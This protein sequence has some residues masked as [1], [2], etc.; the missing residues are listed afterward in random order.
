MTLARV[1]LELGRIEGFPD[2]SS[3]HGYE[4]VA[5]L[6]KDG[7]IDPSEWSAHKDRCRVRRF[8]GPEPEENG[9]L[10][11]HG[12]HG[13]YFDYPAHPSEE[14]EPFFRLDRHHLSSGAYVSITEHDGVQRP[15]KVV[16]IT[17]IL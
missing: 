11:R 8:W 9:L 12:Q 17:P 6:T 5:P 1:R 13:W 14:D 4:F 2:G 16:E 7:H 15:F 10:K 3:Q